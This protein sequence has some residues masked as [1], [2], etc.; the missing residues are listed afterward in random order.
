MKPLK[1]SSSQMGHTGKVVIPKSIRNSMNLG[2]GALLDLYI[3]GNSI[4]LI[5]HLSG[6]ILCGNMEGLKN[7]NGKNVCESCLKDAGG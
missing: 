5:K 2:K 6:C 7:F 4:V 3:D 1:M